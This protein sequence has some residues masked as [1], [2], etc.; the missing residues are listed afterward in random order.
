MIALVKQSMSIPEESKSAVHEGF[1]PCLMTTEYLEENIPSMFDALLDCESSS[2]LVV[3]KARMIQFIG[4]I[5][6]EI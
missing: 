5:V 2:F 1:D 3:M 4:G 6:S